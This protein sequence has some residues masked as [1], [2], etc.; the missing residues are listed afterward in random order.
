MVFCPMFLTAWFTFHW[1]VGFWAPAMPPTA[2]F[3]AAGSLYAAFMADKR[4]LKLYQAIVAVQREKC[5]LEE[6][7]EVLDALLNSLFD[8][9]C[10]CNSHG[11]LTSSSN[12]LEEFLGNP[13]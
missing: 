1:D 12:K 8:A 6:N 13:H 4:E 10:V 11:M 2:F 9:S 5:R 7:M 3:I